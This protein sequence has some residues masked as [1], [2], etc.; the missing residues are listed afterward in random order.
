[1]ALTITIPGAIEATTGAT[2]PAVLTI[3]VGIPGPGVPTG[4]TA[5]QV[6][7]KLSSTNYDTD[8]QTDLNSGVWGSITG[9]L[10]SQTDLQTALNLKANLA[11]PALTGV[12]TAPTAA[13]LMIGGAPK[14]AAFAFIMRLLV[15]GLGAEQLVEEWSRM[16]VVMAVLG[17]LGAMLLGTFFPVALA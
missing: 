14:L 15:Q 1:M 12:P 16:L 6:L 3:G 7:K 5:G 9:T 17:I 13:T 4:G 8:W 2:A 11:S 10:S